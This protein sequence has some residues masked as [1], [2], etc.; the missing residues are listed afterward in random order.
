[1]TRRAAALAAAALALA[2]CGGGGGGRFDDQADAVRTAVASGDRSSALAALDE[3]A[4]KGLEAHAAGDLTDGEVA[5]LGQLVEQGRGL[6]D[7][8]LPEPTTTTT[9]TTTT[10]PPAPFV[11]D[12]EDD[13]D[14]G[15]DRDDRKGKGRGSKGDD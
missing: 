15:H 13:D 6:V 8:Q 9:T 12:D 14:G 10:E 2:A 11:S 4:L 3:I 5:E 7:D 1:M